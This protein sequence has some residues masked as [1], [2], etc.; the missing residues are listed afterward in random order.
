MRC[1]SVPRVLLQ[2]QRHCMQMSHSLTRCW[3][4]SAPNSR[5]RRFIVSKE[6]RAR[7]S[8][9]G[10]NTCIVG[11]SDS[12]FSLKKNFYSIVERSYQVIWLRHAG[13]FQTSM[14]ANLGIWFQEPLTRP[15]VK[16][17]EKMSMI[18]TPQDHRG[19]LQ[20]PACWK[21]IWKWENV[22]PCCSWTCISRKWMWIWR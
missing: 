17:D 13:V 7:R 5:M 22:M 10:F 12:R 20:I 14:M 6:A 18:F 11:C 19:L 1:A 3:L 8:S 21:M 2:G 9:V 15:D 16:L 4:T